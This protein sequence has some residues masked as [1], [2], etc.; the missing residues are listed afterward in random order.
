MGRN[1]A[2]NRAIPSSPTMAACPPQALRQE[3]EPVRRTV[4][5]HN[6]PMQMQMQCPTA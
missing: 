4:G 3:S 6:E 1:Q 5:S 2:G